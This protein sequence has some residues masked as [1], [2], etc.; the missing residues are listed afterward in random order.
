MVKPSQLFDRDRNTNTTWKHALRPI[1]LPSDTPIRG[2]IYRH[3]KVIPVCCHRVFGR[4]HWIVYRSERQERGVHTLCVKCLR[5]QSGRRIDGAERREVRET[6]QPV[7]L[8]GWGRWHRRHDLAR[9]LTEDVGGRGVG[10]VG[11]LLEKSVEN[12]TRLLAY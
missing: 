10:V 8:L 3:K 5:R 9:N 11:R 12:A 6:V 7:V 1:R 4:H 2:G